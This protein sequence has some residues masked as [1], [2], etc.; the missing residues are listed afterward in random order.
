MAKGDTHKQCRMCEKILPIGEFARNGKLRESKND[1]VR[2][3]CRE[4]NSKRSKDRYNPQYARDRML[5]KYDITQDEY[6]YIL[7]AQKGVCAI[8]KSPEPGGK[9]KNFSVDHDHETEA[10]RGL[11]CVACNTAL[12]LI[13]DKVEVL[14]EMISYLTVGGTIGRV[15]GEVEK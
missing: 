9:C 13:K 10:V 11:L 4:C 12:G 15:A 8:C 1:G 6:N 3:Y 14:G 5:A 7:I 2:S